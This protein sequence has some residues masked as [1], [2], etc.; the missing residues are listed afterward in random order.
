VDSYECEPG[1]IKGVTLDPRL[2]QMLIGRIHRSHLEVM[3]A[4]DPQT[5][6]FL[7]Q[8][9]TIRSNAMTE[10]S[11]TPIVVVS[12]ELRLAFKRFFESSFP[13][14]VVLSYQELPSQ[15][16]IQS[17]GIIMAPPGMRTV[18]VQVPDAAAAGR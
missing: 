9:L 14:L 17:I 4:I 7:L 13:K 3:L 12:G 15:T 10:Q 2:E 11:L 16:E 5:A 1:K 8:E 6:Q 18:P